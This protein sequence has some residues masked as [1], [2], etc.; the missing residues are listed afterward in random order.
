MSTIHENPSSR[1]ERCPPEIIQD[2][3]LHSVELAENESPHPS[4]APLVFCQ[5]SKAWRE[6]AINTSQLWT[7]MV[8][9]ISPMQEKEEKVADMLR[10]QWLPR[11]KHQLL[12]VVLFQPQHGCFT[13]PSVSILG[14]IL[15]T[16]SRWRNLT[17][18]AQIHYPI[19]VP[20]HPLSNLKTIAFRP[21]AY[22]AEPY[23]WTGYAAAR[24]VENVVVGSSVCPPLSWIHWDSITSWTFEHA[25]SWHA[26][27]ILPQLPHLRELRF[28]QMDNSLLHSSPLPTCLQRH[29]S[30]RILELGCRTVEE[31]SAFCSVFQ[32]PELNSLSVKVLQER[33]WS[34]RET[35]LGQ[36]SFARFLEDCSMSLQHFSYDR[37]AGLEDIRPSLVNLTSLKSFHLSC[38]SLSKPSLTDNLI[39]SLTGTSILFEEKG[40]LLPALETLKLQGVFSFAS[41]T[42]SSFLHSRGYLH[43]MGTEKL[44]SPPDND[45]VR[46]SALLI[47]IDTPFF[48]LSIKSYEELKPFRDQGL[49]I[50]VTCR[51][52]SL[53]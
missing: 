29:L 43:S 39:T 37:D 52:R 17:I 40:L 51:G 49:N 32:F 47:D 30:L 25:P 10:V 44:S 14:A 35:F 11:S 31:L 26:V 50:A 28:E 45:I 2:I 22:C 34:D 19:L 41:S 48:G 5:V 6:L 18:S 38:R 1:Y 12:D 13:R 42:L 4:S 46:L 27:S 8:V 53:W 16:T 15:A 23:K 7:N 33:H 36:S 21:T 20:S 9:D 24:H 3:M